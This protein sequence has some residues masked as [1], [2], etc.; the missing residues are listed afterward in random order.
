MSH[1]SPAAASR[2]GLFRR[3]LRH[4]RSEA[5]TLAAV[6]LIDAVVSVWS[7]QVFTAGN[8]ANIA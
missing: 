2:A 3:N 8:I 5:A 6:V 4:Y 1:P 7:P